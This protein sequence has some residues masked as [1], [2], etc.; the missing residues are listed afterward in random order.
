MPTVKPPMRMQVSSGGVIYRERDGGVDVALIARETPRGERV[1][2]LPKGWVEPG[3]SPEA[4]ALREVREE[5]G[6]EGEIR[7]KIGEIEY[8]FYSKE[9]RMKVHK[10]VHFFLLR[11]LR[12]ETSDHDH[13]VLEA[14][15]VPLEEAEGRMAYPNEREIMEKA[16]AILLGSGVR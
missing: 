9:H 7:E 16:R 12:G 3:E 6:L 1:W 11:Y 2:C 15:W 4:A 13:E 5:T 10:R 14:A 8:W